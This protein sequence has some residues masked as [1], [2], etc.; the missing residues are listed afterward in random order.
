MGMFPETAPDGPNGA[1][2]IEGAFQSNARYSVNSRYERYWDANALTHF[3]LARL[4]W[5]PDEKLEDIVSLFCR[6][7]Y[8]PAAG[9]HMAKY[10]LLKD[11]CIRKSSHPGEKSPGDDIANDSPTVSGKWCFAW[12]WKSPLGRYA[13]RLFMTTSPKQAA[14]NAVPLIAHLRAAR[15][16]A[17]GTKNIEIRERVEKEYDLLKLYLLSFGCEIDEHATDKI[18]FMRVG[19]EDA[20]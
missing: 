7:H 8:G 2:V 15:G 19:R 9:P 6:N 4:G 14:K 5:N 18:K 12:N 20:E 13:E 1:N 11:E 10:F 17:Y 16:A 3:T